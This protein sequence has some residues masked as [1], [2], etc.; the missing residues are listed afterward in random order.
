MAEEISKTQG[1]QEKDP[2]V[3]LENL[4]S[5]ILLLAADAET[6]LKTIPAKLVSKAEEISLVYEDAVM[7]LEEAQVALSKDQEAKMHALDLELE[8]MSSADQASLWSED[9][10][11]KAP[12]WVAI[13]AQA[14]TVLKTFGRPVVAPD[15]T[16]IAWVSIH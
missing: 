13:R 3:V 4:I 2:K 12:Q 15:A 11:R 10:L 16:K 8:K 7:Q 9:A 6:Q 5:S 1:K 14:A